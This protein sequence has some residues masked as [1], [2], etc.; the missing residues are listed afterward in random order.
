MVAHKKI[1]SVKWTI[2]ATY[3][4]RDAFAPM[5]NVRLRALAAA[6]L[7]A[8]AAALIGW[9]LTKTLLKPLSR[10]QEKVEKFDSKAT[11]ISIFDVKDEDE[12][13]VL[14]RALYSLSIHRQQAEHN[15]HMLATTDGLTGASNRRVLDELLPKALAR[16]VR[17]KDHVAVAFLDIDKFKSINDTHGHAVGDAVLVEFTNRLRK[18]VR[19]TDTV[20]RLAG[21]EFVLIFEQLHA[22]D[23]T[24]IIA[25]KILNA[26][27]PPFAI[28][29]Q[30]LHVTTSIGVAFSNDSTVTA[31]LLMRAS[32]DALY[33]VKAT[34]RNNY[35][36]LEVDDTYEAEE[37][38]A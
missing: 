18:A 2:V 1:P 38:V 5:L 9:A 35:T 13:G 11:D 34:G 23:E 7:F 20:V 36:V 3:P 32:D 22:I 10:L 17:A 28:G 4:I 8:T 16:A 6:A 19:S 27:I 12:F 26:M 37:K 31:D 21:D 30:R 33:K 29:I 25:K 15:L 24:Q 14:S